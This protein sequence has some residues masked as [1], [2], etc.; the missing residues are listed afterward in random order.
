MQFICYVYDVDTVLE[1]AS[2]VQTG[3]VKQI[4]YLI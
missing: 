3:V 1:L 4:Y 2:M